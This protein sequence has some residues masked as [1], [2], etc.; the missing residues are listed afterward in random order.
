MKLCSLLGA[1][2]SVLALASAA[3]GQ[4]SGST[5]DSISAAAIGQLKSGHTK[6]AI[7]DFFGTNPLMSGKQNDLAV[8]ESQISSTIAIFGP[9]RACEL[10]ESAKRGTLI[11]KRLYLC[12]HNH[13]VSCWRLLLMRT[14]DGW[15]GNNFSFDEKVMLKIDED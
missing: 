2:F 1:A 13:F 15:V 4:V 9:L 7:S 5:P 14:A 6:Q 3:N 12:Q 11:E 8:L 10:V